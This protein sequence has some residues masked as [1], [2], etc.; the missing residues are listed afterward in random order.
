MI[1]VISNGEPCCELFEL[2]HKVS[3]QSQMQNREMAIG[4]QVKETVSVF[5]KLV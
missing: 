3:I 4:W 5:E 2:F 1:I